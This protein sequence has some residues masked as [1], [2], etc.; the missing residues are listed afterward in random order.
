MGA[1]KVYDNGGRIFFFLAPPLFFSSLLAGGGD[2]LN[3][4]TQKSRAKPQNKLV[5]IIVVPK[6]FR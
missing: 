4:N 2:G 1:W 5:A 6:L 3:S